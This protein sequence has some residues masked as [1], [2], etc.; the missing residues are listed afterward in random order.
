MNRLYTESHAYPTSH[1]LCQLPQGKG[2]MLA[3]NTLFTMCDSKPGLSAARSAT[4]A[5]DGTQSSSMNMYEEA[6]VLTWPEIGTGTPPADVT[7]FSDFNQL[8][9]VS[10]PLTVTPVSHNLQTGHFPHSQTS[11][12]RAY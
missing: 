5:E 6:E 7:N 12:L 10:E 11:S 9:D 4:L 1:V 2:T 8:F 3:F